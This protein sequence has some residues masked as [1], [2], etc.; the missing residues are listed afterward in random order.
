MAQ[1]WYAAKNS[2]DSRIADRIVARAIPVKVLIEQ[3]KSLDP[4]QQI[5]LPARRL[6]RVI[7]ATDEPR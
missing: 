2:F 6:G 3:L 7:F 4:G 5:V 1:R